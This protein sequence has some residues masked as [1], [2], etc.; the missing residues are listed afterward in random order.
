MKYNYHS[1]HFVGFL[2]FFCCFSLSF[3]AQGTSP[4][5]QIL[6]Y[7]QD[8]STLSATAAT[9]PSGFQGWTASVIP[10]S[11]YNTTA[12]L[13][14]DKAVTASGTAS[15]T[16]GNMYNYNGKIGFLN[17]GSFDLTLGFAFKTVGQSGITVQYDA[18][19]IRNPYNGTTNDRINELAMQ[20]RIGDT[21]SFITLPTT[22]YLSNTIAQST[23]TAAVN[24]QTIKVQ[25]PAECN[26]KTLIQIRWISKQN[27]GGGS[28]PSFAIDNLSVI[29]DLIPPANESGYPKISN[30]LSGGFDFSS[31]LDEIG[32]T[33]FVL[34]P[35]GSA[36][37]GKA[38]IKT[39]T[40][41]NDTAASKAG[42]L[43]VT[44]PTIA[45]VTT[46]TGLDFGTDYVLY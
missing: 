12:A 22:A 43:L 34:L 7:T 31:Q 19:V 10:G 44:N 1:R 14:G 11:S 5:A 35:I 13:V 6:P 38:Q 39:G 21:T 42:V 20:Y 4:E 18:M 37:P 41:A 32:K 36:K 27:S 9:Y 30:I 29:N 8:F 17:T 28:R 40:N 33:Y 26:N 46:I 45:Y 23:G 16:S 2:S 3:F 15:S 25:L 24:P